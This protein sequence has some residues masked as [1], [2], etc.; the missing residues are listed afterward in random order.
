M[1]KFLSRLGDSNE[2]EVRALQPIVERITALEPEIQAL[3]DADLAAKTDE[4][5]ARLRDAIG[6]ILTPPELRETDPDEDASESALAGADAARLADELKQQ[7][8]RELKRINEALDAILPEA[9]AAVRE[10]MWPEPEEPRRFRN[11][12]QFVVGSMR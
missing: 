11:L 3:S 7:R 8:Q 4:F 1:F 5:R 12:V 9:F 10:A 6:D 2:R